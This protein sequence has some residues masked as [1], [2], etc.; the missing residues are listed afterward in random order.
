MKNP[1]TLCLLFIAVI[2][3]SCNNS[4]FEKDI[5]M[6]SETWDKVINDANLDL[7]NNTHFTN[8]ITLISHPENVVGIEAVKAYYQNFTTGFSDI[9]FTVVN[10]FGQNDNIV[11]HWNFK[12]THTGDFFGIPATGNTVNIDGVTLVKM[13]D[14]KIAEE[15]DFMDSTVFMQQLGIASAPGNT[16]VINSLY[17]AFA[18]GEIPTVLDLLDADVIWN[19]A[20]GNAYADGNPYKGP[21]AVLNGVFARIG[22]DHEYFKLIDI[23]L[24]DMSENKV[25]ATLRYDAK[26][27]KTGKTY[28][29]QVAH[30]WTLKDGKVIS[31]QQYVDTKKLADAT[32]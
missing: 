22:A 29:A 20:E 16:E 12:G 7:I 11:K 14:G 5:K 13:K 23:H 32:K 15:Q 1:I 17:N 19:E 2:T 4:K 24:H 6:Y 8:D 28:N 31:F 21:E 25:L 18:V 9:K 26:V 10:I 3:A 27:K 30:L